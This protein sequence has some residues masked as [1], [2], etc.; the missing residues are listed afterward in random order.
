MEGGRG[1]AGQRPKLD[2]PQP[3]GVHGESAAAPMAAACCCCCRRSAAAATGPAGWVLMGAR[4]LSG[5]DGAKEQSICVQR[6]WRWNQGSGA[7]RPA[8]ALFHLPPGGDAL[9]QPHCR[10]AGPPAAQGG[11]GSGARGQTP[12]RQ[13]QSWRVHGAF[14]IPSP[15]TVGDRIK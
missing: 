11:C 13:T 10:R 9:H 1:A 14:R 7:E 5:V 4:T 6:G 15:T 8:A 12:G 2:I 3:V